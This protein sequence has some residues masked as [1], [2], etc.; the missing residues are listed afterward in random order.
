[1][2]VVR[3]GGRHGSP[4]PYNDELDNLTHTAIGLFLSRAGLNRWTP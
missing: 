1:M 4:W 3:T 2:I